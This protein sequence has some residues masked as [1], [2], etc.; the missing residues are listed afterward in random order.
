ML[1]F[2]RHKWG[3]VRHLKTYYIAFDLSVFE[4]MDDFQP[5]KEDLEI[6]DLILTTIK[7][8][9]NEE[10]P[11]DLERRLG[12]VLKSNKAERETLLQILAYCGIL[13]PTEHSGFFKSYTDSIDRTMPSVNKIDWT[14][15]IWWWR[16]Q[17]RFN[18]EAVDFW[19]AD[20]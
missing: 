4:Q 17:D 19:F 12:K 16:G 7:Q 11:R 13:Q 3:G 9:K 5:K 15:P 10:R 6:L 14:Y 1:N 2:E 8:S 18:Q 20:L